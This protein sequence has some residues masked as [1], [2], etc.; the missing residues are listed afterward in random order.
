MQKVMGSILIIAATSGAGY[1]YGQELKQ[2]LEKLLYLRYVTGLIRGE[3]E[4]TCAPLPEV[5]A[6]VAAR[7]REPYRTWLRETARETGER[8]EAGFSR[9]WN[10]CV[11]RYLD[12]LGL[13]TEHS[14]LLKELGTFLGQVDAETADRS[15]QLYI[16]RMDLAIENVRENL[17]SRKRIG[18]CLGVMGG[19][20]LVVVLI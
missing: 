20:F 14:I 8:S 10:R 3:M 2:Y 7:V 19:I 4:Y 13:K 9:I 17:A 15:L 16:N 18:N 11:D 12:M 5:F 6:A 1:V